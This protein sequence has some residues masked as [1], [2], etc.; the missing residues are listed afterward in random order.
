MPSLILLKPISAS[1]ALTR[2]LLNLRMSQTASYSK[3]LFDKAYVNG[4]WVSASS[5]KT[6][7]VINP[8]D[9][10]VIASVPDM[11]AK[12][13][14][15]AIQSAY[16]AFQT[17]KKTTAKERSAIMKK[18]FALMVENKSDLAH[19]LTLENGKPYAD[20]LGEITYGANFCEWYAEEARRIYGEIIPSPIPTKR[21]L[22]LR[23]PVGVCGMITPWNFPNAM[24]TRKAC[25][26]LAAGC[27]VVIKPAEDTPLS[28]LAL[29]DFAEKAGVPPGVFNVVTCDRSNAPSVG[30]VLCE[31]PLVTAISFTGSSATGKILLQQSA[32]TVKKCSMEL[33]GNAPFI[34]FNSA[35]LDAAVAG[36]IACKFRCSGQTCI[37]ANRI[38]VQEG[39]YDAFV[40]KLSAAIDKELRIGDGMEEGTTQ[41]PLINSKAVEKVDSLVQDAIKQG[42]IAVRGGKRHPRGPNFYEP[43]LLSN[44]TLNMRCVTEEIFGPVAPIVKFKTE[45][46]ALTIANGTSAGLAGY[47]FTQDLGQVWRVAEGLDFGIV[48]V[49]EGIISAPEAPFGGFKESGLGREGGKYGID[50]FIEIK[51]VCIGGL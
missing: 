21:L 24:V 29:C 43:T 48:G 12:D 1:L 18:W 51:Y 39:V 20:A 23:Q 11:D 45:E 32:S 40:K 9:G 25:A 42:A 6:Y 13:T 22:V 50:D 41:G 33:G 36:T 4:K 10:K 35:N 17:W 49:N 2:N 3:V 31:S 16:T 19:L 28:A 47:L 26:A 7:N 46:E 30:K 37:C 5:G 14:T 38:L 44:V 15:A 34:V 27:T 8:S